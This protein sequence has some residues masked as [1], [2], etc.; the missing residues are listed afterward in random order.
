MMDKKNDYQSELFEEFAKDRDKRRRFFKRLS[1]SKK[2]NIVVSQDKLIVYL[3]AIIILFIITF[4]LGVERGKRIKIYSEAKKNY[5]SKTNEREETKVIKQ[6]GVKE[7]IKPIKQIAKPPE[8]KFLP[9]KS[10]KFF[11]VQVAAFKKSYQAEEELKNIKSREKDA[12]ILKRGKFNIIYVGKFKNKEEALCKQE[13]LKSKY[14][15]CF[16]KE[17]KGDTIYRK[18]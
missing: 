10:I 5:I 17:I 15:D 11:T 4:S 8:T 18:N 1:D 13:E 16:I 6:V 7:E 9:D 2:I 14:K 12:F 3:I